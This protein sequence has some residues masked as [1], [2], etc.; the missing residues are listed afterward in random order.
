MM[1]KEIN[2]VD[3]E[4]LEAVRAAGSGSRGEIIDRVGRG[5]EDVDRSLLTLVEAGLVAV[6]KTPR[7]TRGGRPG[8]MSHYEL[9]PRAQR[10]APERVFGSRWPSVWHYGDNRRF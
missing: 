6:R 4:V 5:R 2:S 3:L 1:P 7:R 8:V 9:T 10:R